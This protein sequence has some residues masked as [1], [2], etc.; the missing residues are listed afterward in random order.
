MVRR[1]RSCSRYNGKDQGDSHVLGAHGC[2]TLSTGSRCSESCPVVVALL[3]PMLLEPSLMLAK[4]D[5][6]KKL[7]V[8]DQVPLAPASV[9][10]LCDGVVVAT[11]LASTSKDGP[12]DPSLSR[13]FR[14]D[15][16]QEV[17]I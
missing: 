16:E 17:M 9:V 15:K 13:C 3:A 11:E 8:A 14:V 12:V 1:W 2:A 7:I 6:R 5:L 10:G 4:K